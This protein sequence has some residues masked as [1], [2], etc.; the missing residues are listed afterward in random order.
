MFELSNVTQGEGGQTTLELGV[1]AL[2][3]G[4]GY[5]W[6]VFATDKSGVV[7]PP[8]ALEGFVIELNVSSSGADEGCSAV[9]MARSAPASP[10]GMLWALSMM[11]FMGVF[12]LRRRR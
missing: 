7:G 5:F 12:A 11:A 9:S 10:T 1:S 4:G 2:K 3:A 6:Q 8:S